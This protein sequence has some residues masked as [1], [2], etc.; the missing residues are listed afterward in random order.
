MSLE[1]LKALRVPLLVFAAV[2]GAATALVAYS[3]AARESERQQ[4]AQR[5]TELKHAQLRI[6]NAGR[7][8][9]I[10]AQYLTAFVELEKIGFVGDEQR[11]DWLDGLREANR[12]VG[13]YGVEYEISAQRAYTHAA[14]LNPGAVRLR[15]S[16][17]R[18][19]LGLLHEIDL[20][21]FLHALAQEGAGFFT[22]DQCILRRLRAEVQ[23]T[24]PPEPHLLAE[25]EL[26]WLTAQPPPSQPRR[27]P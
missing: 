12:R 11:M 15:Q 27:A 18:V 23:R 17:M 16:T 22:V 2:L 7:E 5:E 19:R 9:E 3:G 21:R 4:L 13:L 10:V 8:R 26:A 14:D 24:V 1:D 20:Q 25:C 6:Q